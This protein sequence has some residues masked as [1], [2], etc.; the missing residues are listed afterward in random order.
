VIVAE[1]EGRDLIYSDGSF[2]A[3]TP[4]PLPDELGQPQTAIRG[5]TVVED[6]LPSDVRSEAVV[7]PG[8]GEHARAAFRKLGATVIFDG[9]DA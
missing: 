5:E 2:S 9:G 7:G 1:F 8:T 3:S 6:G 4:E